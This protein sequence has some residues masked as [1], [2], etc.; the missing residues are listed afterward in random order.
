M[1]AS[2]SRTSG[3]SV[4]GW[5]HWLRGGPTG[6]DDLPVTRAPR[7]TLGI[8]VAA[9]ILGILGIYWLLETQTS[10][11]VPL[12][13][14]TT[15][16]LS[17][18]A[19]WLLARKHIENWP[20]WIVGVNIPF[21]A[22]YLYKGLALTASLQLVFI[23]LSVMGWY[24]VAPAARRAPTR[25]P[26]ARAARSPR[27]PSGRTMTTGVVVGKFRP[28][29]RGH[30]L[31]IDTAAASVDRLFVLSSAAASMKQHCRWRPAPRGCDTSTR[32]RVS[33]SSPAWSTMPSRS[34]TRTSSTSGTRPSCD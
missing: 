21:I 2:R 26:P 13:D 11:T 18:V 22:I 30:K 23:G 6:S 12:A 10:S 1:P 34:R 33:A 16:T 25:R 28:P 20:L 5:F 17:L 19:S 7:G 29:H 24:R 31:L 15:T 32:S 4:Y 9:S 8:C 27:D 3:L 14:A